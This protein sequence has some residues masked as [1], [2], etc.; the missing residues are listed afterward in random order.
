M[1][2]V[3]FYKQERFVNYFVFEKCSILGCILLSKLLF[4][5]SKSVLRFNVKVVG[6]DNEMKMIMKCTRSDAVFCKEGLSNDDQQFQQYQLH[7]QLSLSPQHTKTKIHADGNAGPGTINM[8][9]F[10]FSILKRNI[11]SNVDTN[12]SRH[13]IQLYHKNEDADNLF[14]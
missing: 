12:M 10:L 11:H 1:F 9:G 8:A 14:L 2:F 3:Y 4:I 6:H 5:P 13:I 7:E